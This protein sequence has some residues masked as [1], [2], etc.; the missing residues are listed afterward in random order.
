MCVCVCVCV[1]AVCAVCVCM[2]VYVCVH[3]HVY[4]NIIPIF[5]LLFFHKTTKKLSSLIR[6]SK[7]GL[8]YLGKATSATGA[9]LPF[10]TS[11]VCAAFPCVQT[12]E[13]LPAYG[14]FNMLTDVSACNC[15]QGLC[16]H[17]EI[18]YP[19][20]GDW[21]KNP[22]PHWGIKPPSVLCLTFWSDT[23][24]SELTPPHLPITIKQFV[25]SQNRNMMPPS[26][27]THHFQHHHSGFPPDLH[28]SHGDADG[29]LH[30]I[31]LRLLL[32]KHGLH[33]RPL[34]DRPIHAHEV[35]QEMGLN[36]CLP[37]L[38]TD[39]WGEAVLWKLGLRLD[40]VWRAIQ[41]EKQHHLDHN[42]T[43][44]Q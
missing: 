26:K 13:Y 17:C 37:V 27:H 8:P 12:M 20:G 18:V 15:T 39:V 19:E 40:V 41:H 35:Q 44:H 7:F 43:F 3:V 5:S 4:F 6:Y 23:L 14:I 32:L 10:P 25:I 38:R 28:C 11:A 16:K 36:H 24:P 22:M 31:L 21:E 30:A 29:S 42:F 34:L 1:C 33:Q 2:C 9:M